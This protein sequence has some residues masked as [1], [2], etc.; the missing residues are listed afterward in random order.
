M[1]LAA[2]AA[3]STF[4]TLDVPSAGNVDPSKVP[5]NDPPGGGARPNA[6]KALVLLPDGYDATQPYPVLYLLGGHGETYDAWAHPTRGDVQ[7][8][9][10]GFPGIVVMPE[11][12][13]GWYANWWNSGK[14]GEPAWE[15]YHLDELIPAVERRYP[16]RPERRWHAIAGNSMG[17]LGAMFYASQRPGYFGA[18]ASFSGVLAPDRADWPAGIQTQG[19][20]FEDV[21]GPERYY[22]EGHSPTRLIRSLRATR[23]FTRNGNGVPAPVPEQLRNVTGTAFE[24]YLQLQQ[25]DFD[26]GARGIGASLDSAVHQGIHDWPY[27][28][29]NLRDAAKWDFFAPVE[30]SP[31]SW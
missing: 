6:L 13:K 26:Q 1:V 16:I 20:S 31:K 7:K 15:R 4:E 23:L 19:E 24:A 11:G 21:Y 25:A 29:Q 17:G 27:W 12:A 14:R 2:P 22:V 5:F 18:A 10:A 8:T 30:E 3:A 9:L 28:R